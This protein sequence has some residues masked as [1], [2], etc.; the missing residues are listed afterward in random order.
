MLL[1]AFFLHC[2]SHFSYA[3]ACISLM[4]LLALLLHCCLHFSYAAARTS[5]MLLLALCFFKTVAAMLLLLSSLCSAAD[6]IFTDH[7]V[8]IHCSSDMYKMYTYSHS[9]S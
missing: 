1:L 6:Y 8:S 4:L 3:A 9:L 5:L 7:A 2:C